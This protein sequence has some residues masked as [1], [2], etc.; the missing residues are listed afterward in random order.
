MKKIIRL[1]IILIILVGCS[2]SEEKKE[3]SII[4]PSGAPALAFYNH[5]DKVDIADASAIKTQIL[6]EDGEDIA[7][8]PINI[9]VSLFNSGINYKMS[10]IITFGNFYICDLGK[11][12]NKVM[13]AGDK[14]VLFSQGS[15][16]DLLFHYIYED[17]YDN[18]ITYLNSAT[19][20]LREIV[21]PNSDAQYVLIAEPALSL[22]LE[23]NKQASIYCSLQDLYYEKTNSKLLQACILV[24][25]NEDVDEFLSSLQNDVDALINNPELLNEKI[26]EIGF[27]KEEASTIFGNVEANIKA[28]KNDNAVGIG[29]MDA[30]ENKNNIDEYLKLFNIGET[31]EEIY[32]K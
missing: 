5:L 6:N 31:S 28:L 12:E 8:L 15:I 2:K 20:A 32:Y 11:D 29:Y 14:I 1:F 9:A 18:S 7:V 10:S 17:I 22:A 27:D 13:D 16:P 21:N 24:K 25:D 3:L 4:C 23:K 26:E 19:E 30:Y